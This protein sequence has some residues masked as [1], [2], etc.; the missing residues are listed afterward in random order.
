[1][2][3]RGWHPDP[4]GDGERWHDGTRWSGVT[5]PTAQSA[6]RAARVEAANERRKRSARRGHRLRVAA[7]VVV[8]LIVSSGLTFLFDPGDAEPIAEALGVGRP[9]RLLPVVLPVVRSADYT[10]LR[11]DYEGDPI[12]Y[13]P[14]KAVHYV[15]NP[16]GA[17]TDYRSFVD[18]AIEKAQAA[19]GLKFV[20]DG[21]TDDTWA[22]RGKVTR[23]EPVLISFSSPMDSSVA[24]ADTVGLGGSTSM[25][26]DGL[27]QPH[28][29][30]GRADLLSTWFA[31]ES[32]IHGTGAEESVVMHELGHV[33]GLGHV[34]DRNEVMYSEAH[35]Q[36]TYG[37]GDLAGLARL[38]AGPCAD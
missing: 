32:A 16:A 22:T 35:G 24:G 31:H 8:S 17:P 6:V 38:G 15:I 10:I 3:Q 25:T 11:T 30:T 26:I 37:P 13:D 20:Y 2:T 4:Q 5:R 28:Y 9:H 27:E 14:C 34:Q 1:M 33:L 29:L 12:S 7:L 18:P 21:L 23:S 36:T 19:A